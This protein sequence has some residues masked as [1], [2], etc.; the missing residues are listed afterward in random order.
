MSNNPFLCVVVLN[1]NH[2]DD[3]IITLDS[4]LNQNYNNYKII[5]SDNNSSDGSQKYI[6]EHY[7]NV[8]LLENKDNLGW[9]AGNNVGVKYALGM[10]AEYVLLANNDIY[11]EETNII[12]T[13]LKDMETLKDKNIKI[14]GT[15][16]NYYNQK[17]KLHNDGWIMYPKSEQRGKY[18]NKYRYETTLELPCKYKLV[19][20][21]SGCFILIDCTLFHEIG[22]IDE[23]FFIYGEETEFSFRAWKAGYGSVINKDLTIYHKISAT[24]KVGSPFSMYLKTRNLIYLLKKHKEDIIYFNHYRNKYYFDFIKTIM[25]IILYPGIFNGKQIDI[26]KSTTS[27]FIDGV[28]FNRL[29]KKGIKF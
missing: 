26:L 17:E 11:L 2:L 25:K 8:I 9:A 5:V 14:I 1:W 16:V 3:L 27:G 13:L 28:F 6:R 22:L 18:F 21:V 4:I 19:D 20:F 12:Q 10:G 29:G 24:N 15:N 7:P 23:A